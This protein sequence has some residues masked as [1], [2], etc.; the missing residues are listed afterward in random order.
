[1]AQVV[2]H[3]QEF[4]SLNAKVVTISFGKQYWARAWLQETQSPYPL[5]LDPD[6]IAYR[7]YGLEHS[8]L[9]SWNARTIS[10][11]I[12]ALLNGQEWRGIRGDSGQ[13]GG[14][15]IVDR[16]GIVRFAYTSHDPTDRPTVDLLLTTLRQ[17]GHG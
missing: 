5:L 6:R 15:F 4:E 17:L 7:A 13:L 3:Q 11:H 14:D 12:R 10:Y 8:F 9:R 1:M 16:Q 2:S